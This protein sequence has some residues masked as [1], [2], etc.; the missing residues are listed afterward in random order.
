MGL[1]IRSLAPTMNL[2]LIIGKIIRVLHT[3]SLGQLF[4]GS[5]GV[6]LLGWGWSTMRGVYERWMGVE[7]GEQ[8]SAKGQGGEKARAQE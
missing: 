1:S 5:S 6:L 2:T 4:R 8:G 7:G 3:A